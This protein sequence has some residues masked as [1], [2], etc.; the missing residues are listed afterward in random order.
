MKSL[1]AFALGVIVGLLLSSWFSTHKAGK[2]AQN[3]GG[4]EPMPATRENSPQETT[5]RL[6]DQVTIPAGEGK[7]VLTFSAMTIA[8]TREMAEGSSLRAVYP[9]AP[10]QRFVLLEVNSHNVGQATDKLSRQDWRIEVEQGAT[11]GLASSGLPFRLPPEGASRDQLIFEIP[12][13][14]F[15]VKLHGAI[16]GRDFIINLREAGQ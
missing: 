4:T 10:H 3:A 1:A 12:E 7:R 8:P 16:N 5:V 13:G 6:H 14:A 15:P 11:Y 9:T 2:P